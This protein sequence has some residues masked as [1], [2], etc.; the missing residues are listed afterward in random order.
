MFFFFL[1][2]LIRFIS[3]NYF[4]LFYFTVFTLFFSKLSPRTPHLLIIS[5]SGDEGYCR[6]CWPQPVPLS[7]GWFCWV[8][9]VQAG[10]RLETPSWADPRSGLTPRPCP[11]R[12][13]ASARGACQMGG[14]CVWLTPRGS[15]TPAWAQMRSEWSW[16]GVWIC[17]RPDRTCSCCCCVPDGWRASAAPLSTGSA[18]RSGR[19]RSGLPWFWSRGA[20][21]SVRN[22][23][24]TSWR[25]A[26]NYGSL[27]ASVR[28]ASTCLITLKVFHHIKNWWHKLISWFPIMNYTIIINISNFFRIHYSR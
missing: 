5:H 15:S 7:C 27:C 20:T 17:R 9:R 23:L 1:N 28:A 13:T 12:A 21:R 6:V 25:R 19:R 26:R 4:I 18:P 16:A 22:P 3:V 8:G 24:R 10:V 14:A 2:I 11:W